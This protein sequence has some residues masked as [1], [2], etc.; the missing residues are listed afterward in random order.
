M[1]R[2][3]AALLVV[4]FALVGTSAASFG[5]VGAD[6]SAFADP[7]FQQLWQRTDSLVASGTVKRSFY[8]GPQPNSGPLMEDFAEG[9]GGKH[10]V[11]YF[12]KSRMEINN[13]NADK[14]SPFYVTNGLLTEELI[15]GKMQ[16]GNNSFVDRWPAMI[17]LASDP[18]DSEAPTYASFRGPVAQKS[19]SSTGQMVDAFIQ[20]SGLTYSTTGGAYLKY[21]VKNAYFEPTTQHNIPDV[22]WNFLTASGPVI[23]NGRQMTKRLND[24]WFYATGYPISEAY[25]ANVEIGGQIQTAVLIQPYE[26]RVLTY[27]PSAPTGFQVQMGNIGQH[28][29]DWRYNNAGKPDALAGKCSS[30]PVGG[31]GQLW[32]NGDKL[33]LELGCQTNTEERVSITIQSFEHGMMIDYNS[34][35]SYTREDYAN[36]FALYQ[37]GSA[38][39]FYQR[40]SDPQPTPPAPPS[41]LFAPGDSFARFWTQPGVEEQLGWATAPQRMF[42]LAPDGSSGGVVQEFETGTMLYP[43]LSSRKIYVVYDSTGVGRVEKVPHN[44]YFQ[45]NRWNVYADTYQP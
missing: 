9:P 39:G 43:D 19:I 23:A 20:R 7:A 30:S 6:V 29:Y 4:L 27:V 11:Q 32:G 33:K 25:W 14:S 22:F 18:D 3:I 5:R 31:F 15:S 44:I 16:V 21:N 37:D 28:Y 45:V 40:L 2:Q 17:D 36:G 12:D 38:Q 10:L 13:P 42:T 24:P 34:K 35:D 26:R 8:W 41:G 1:K